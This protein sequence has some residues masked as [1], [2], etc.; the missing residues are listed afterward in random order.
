MPR[1]VKVERGCCVLN[2]ANKGENNIQHSYKSLWLKE[3][4]YICYQWHGLIDSPY[5]LMKPGFTTKESEI[6]EFFF[7]C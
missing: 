4:N 6:F 5:E 7:T 1:F 3:L 2:C